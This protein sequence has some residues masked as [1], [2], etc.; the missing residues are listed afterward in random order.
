ML[1]ETLRKGSLALTGKDPTGSRHG[2]GRAPTTSRCWTD[3][4]FST[5]GTQSTYGNTTSRDDM[6]NDDV[7]Q[8]P[9][10]F[11]FTTTSFT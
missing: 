6:K 4:N 7:P 5:Y 2:K 10:L 3:E 1:L 9:S 8:F 11:N